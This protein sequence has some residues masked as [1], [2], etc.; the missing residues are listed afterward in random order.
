MIKVI[1]KERWKWG[2][3][4]YGY[5]FGTVYNDFYVEYLYPAATEI[6]IYRTEK[7]ALRGIKKF[8]ESNKHKLLRG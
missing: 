3:H 2:V 1:K 7:G 4:T 6:K 8:E 5:D